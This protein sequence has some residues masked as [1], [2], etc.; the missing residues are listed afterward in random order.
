MSGEIESTA[1]TT[2]RL[3]CPFREDQERLDSPNRSIL[4]APDESTERVSQSLPASQ[5]DLVR[6]HSTTETRETVV[7]GGNH[8]DRREEERLGPD[9]R[10][11][12]FG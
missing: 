3:G 12:V 11:Q 9:Q 8:H 1:V 7:P 4:C 10:G 6:P 5:V 2:H